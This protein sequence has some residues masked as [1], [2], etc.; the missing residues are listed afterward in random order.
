[1][2]P[3]SPG[4]SISVLIF[5][6][7]MGQELLTQTAIVADKKGSFDIGPVPSWVKPVRGE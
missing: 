5:V 4:L 7:A 2:L 1:M 6:L 3:G